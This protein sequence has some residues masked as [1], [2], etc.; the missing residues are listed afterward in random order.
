MEGIRVNL[1]NNEGKADVKM[2]FA[3]SRQRQ[4]MIKLTRRDIIGTKLN[5]AVMMP[6]IT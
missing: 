5:A 2:D 6:K 3:I 1:T 4:M